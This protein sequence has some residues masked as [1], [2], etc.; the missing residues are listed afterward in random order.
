MTAVRAGPTGVPTLQRP[1]MTR[2]TPD[3][4]TPLRSR[5]SRVPLTSAARSR[6]A[7]GEPPRHE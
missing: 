6:T 4:G 2:Q 1:R 3:P 5:N 7:S